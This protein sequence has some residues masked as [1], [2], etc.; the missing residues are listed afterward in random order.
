MY[1]FIYL[2]IPEITVFGKGILPFSMTLG[3]FV[4]IENNKNINVFKK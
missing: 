1:V 4:N 3:Y 2:F